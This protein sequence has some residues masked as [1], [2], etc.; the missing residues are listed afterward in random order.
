M[1]KEDT[2][3]FLCVKTLVVHISK[4]VVQWALLVLVVEIGWDILQDSLGVLPTFV[5]VLAAVEQLDVLVQ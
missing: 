4:L 5:V 2:F 1:S 3:L